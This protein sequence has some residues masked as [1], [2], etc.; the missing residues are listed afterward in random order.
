MQTDPLLVTLDT[1]QLDARRVT[2][3]VE[4]LPADSDITYVTTSD[5]ERL[6]DEQWKRD[7]AR[8][9]ASAPRARP[10][11]AVWG[12]SVW[13]GAAWAS[14][15]AEPLIERVL[16]IIGSGSFPRPGD[17]DDLDGGQRN[18]LADALI[19]EAHCRQHG[20]LLVTIDAKGFI[21]HGRRQLLETLGQTAI[22]T[23]D[24]LELLL[25]ADFATFRR[26]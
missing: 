15:E 3:L 18:Q 20:H 9:G 1:N 23:P 2:R 25:D 5:R 11:T 22:R 16:Q 17:R 7:L 19:F 10:E 8:E 13:G 26:R 6:F 4:L 14:P 24:E 12:E 21:N